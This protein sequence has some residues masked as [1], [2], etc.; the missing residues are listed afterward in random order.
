MVDALLLLICRLEIFF[1]VVGE[2]QCLTLTTINSFFFLVGDNCINLFLFLLVEISR[3]IFISIQ[4]F[5]ESAL[6]L[7]AI[8]KLIV[9]LVVN[10]KENYYS[11][12]LTSLNVTLFWVLSA[13]FR[14]GWTKSFS[15]PPPP[16]DEAAIFLVALGLNPRHAKIRRFGFVGSEK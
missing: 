11:P 9:L 15:A 7:F 2:G 3:K 14:L 1:L 8:W 10:N 6:N 4:I 12:V 16:L 13:S 5:L